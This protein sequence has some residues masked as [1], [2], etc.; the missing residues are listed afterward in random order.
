M[1]LLA[2][3]TSRLRSRRLERRPPPSGFSSSFVIQIPNLRTCEVWNLQ[4]IH[5]FP[6]WLTFT[7]DVDTRK[8]PVLFDF[9]RILETW[10]CKFRKICAAY[11]RRFES[12]AFDFLSAESDSCEEKSIVLFFIVF[13]ILHFISRKVC[14][15][16]VCQCNVCT[17]RS[18]ANFQGRSP[19]RDEAVAPG[20]RDVPD[21]GCLTG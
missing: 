20:R 10:F 18:P 14:S 7:P 2:S 12:K 5:T 6:G 21:P 13:P 19:R 1:P 11:R 16:F 17:F 8:E 3:V 15:A 4:N 9:R